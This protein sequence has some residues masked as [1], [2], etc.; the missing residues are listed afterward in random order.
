MESHLAAYL[1]MK[2]TDL[3]KE[4]KSEFIKFNAETE[5]EEYD[6]V[7]EIEDEQVMMERIVAFQVYASEKHKYKLEPYTDD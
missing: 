4:L 6:S 1:G 3:H 7:A 2:K 5:K